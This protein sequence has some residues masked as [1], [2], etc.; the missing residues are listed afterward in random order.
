MIDHFQFQ[1]GLAPVIFPTSLAPQLILIAGHH[2]KPAVGPPDDPVKKGHLHIGLQHH[3]FLA[4]QG[5]I[6]GVGKSRHPAVPLFPPG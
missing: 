1:T 6:D 3:L 4:S 2:Q 5:T